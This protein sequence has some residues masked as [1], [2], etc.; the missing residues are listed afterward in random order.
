M[1]QECG[2]V[3]VQEEQL[4]VPP[5]RELGLERRGRDIGGMS[6]AGGS[7]P[8]RRR[9]QNN[10]QSPERGERV[11]KKLAVVRKSCEQLDRQMDRAQDG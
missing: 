3:G 10:D 1:E 2:R 8:G 9:A 4:Q 6:W 7:R 11:P 5:T